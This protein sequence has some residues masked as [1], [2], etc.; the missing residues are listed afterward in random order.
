MAQLKRIA[1]LKEAQQWWDGIGC[2]VQDK[3]GRRLNRS[4]SRVACDERHKTRRER[5]G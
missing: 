1:D 2:S 3:K 5:R 4:V